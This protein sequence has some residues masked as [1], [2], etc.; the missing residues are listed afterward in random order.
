MVAIAIKRCRNRTFRL[1]QSGEVLFG[2]TVFSSDRFLADIG[3]MVGSTCRMKSTGPIVSCL[4][5][6][7]VRKPNPIGPL[8]ACWSRNSYAKDVVR[9]TRWGAVG[10][11]NR[12]LK[13]EDI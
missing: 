13:R 12:S 11:S 10:G 7:L 4:G 3:M 9:K 2:R 8:S 5:K 1:A 6:Y